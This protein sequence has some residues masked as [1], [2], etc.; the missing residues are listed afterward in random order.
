MALAYHLGCHVLL[1]LDVASPPV[2]P[3]I[4]VSLLIAGNLLAMMK[5]ISE[6]VV[7]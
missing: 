4:L 6:C 5:M 1:V 2:Q 7:Q 3:V